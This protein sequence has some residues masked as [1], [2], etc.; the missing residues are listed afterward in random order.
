MKKKRQKKDDPWWKCSLCG[1]TLQGAVPP[2]R[3]P[4]CKQVCAFT[5]VSCYTP[6]CGGPGKI[7]Q[8]LMGE[9]KP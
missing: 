1:Y 8:K 7:D 6:E 4:D 3:C 5:D 2:E 9:K